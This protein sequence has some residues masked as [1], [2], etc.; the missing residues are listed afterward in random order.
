MNLLRLASSRRSV[1]RF[2][3][4]PIP[5]SDIE[6]ALDVARHAPSGANRQPWR[7]L[8][9]SDRKTKELIRTR[10]E[11]VE[12]RFH[13]KVSSSLKQWFMEKGITWRKP[14]LT[15]AP[16]LILVFGDVSQP[17]WLESVWIAVG[18]LL[19]AIEELGYG[20]L[21]YT[22]SETSWAAEL[23]NVPKNYRLQ[24]IIPVGKPMDEK[25]QE[26]RRAL[27]EVCYL[28]RWGNPFVNPLSSV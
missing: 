13:E 4:D 26:E 21:T 25:G 16:F 19:L 9:I 27:E 11:E 20:S 2:H 17:Y 6:Y 15:E 3:P 24:A 23:L 28:D 22:P 7:F 1:R 18:Y 8:I 5:L 12:K 10:C 14:F